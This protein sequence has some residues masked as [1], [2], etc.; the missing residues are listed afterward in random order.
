MLHTC[1]EAKEALNHTLKTADRD[2][3]NPNLTPNEKKHIEALEWAFR[4]LVVNHNVLEPRIKK[5]IGAALTCLVAQPEQVLTLHETLHVSTITFPKEEG[6]KVLAQCMKAYRALDE[7]EL[8]D[9]HGFEQDDDGLYH[10][11]EGRNY[12]A[13]CAMID[14]QVGPWLKKAKNHLADI[15]LIKKEGLLLDETDILSRAT[16]LGKGEL[17]PST[18]PTASAVNEYIMTI[19]SKLP[20]AINNDDY[21]A[22][23][24]GFAAAGGKL[25]AKLAPMMFASAQ[26]GNR[27][28]WQ[29][30]SGKYRSVWLT[31]GT[32]LLCPFPMDAGLVLLEA[33]RVCEPIPF[34]LSDQHESEMV[35]YKRKTR[36][37]ISSA[38]DLPPIDETDEEY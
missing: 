12:L 23:N 21:I 30:I 29:M 28:T 34:M 19:T 17:P 33:G 11:E 2:R 26:M 25:L 7:V 10:I 13:C 4:S 1:E 24:V 36:E 5:I 37:V 27:N 8:W 32:T 22:K 9:I 14:M 6:N 20:F 16:L 38:S 15:E 18:N 3:F 35:Q 31:I